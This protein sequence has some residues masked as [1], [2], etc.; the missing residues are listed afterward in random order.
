MVGIEFQVREIAFLLLPFLNLLCRSTNRV[1]VAGKKLQYLILLFISIV[2]V[3]EVLKH[4]YYGGGLGAT[5]KTIRIGLPLFSCLVIL[6]FGL[7]A[8]VEKVWRTLLW[9]ISASAV[10]T[11]I[12]PFVYLP[13]YP[14]IEGEN[15]IEATAGRFI[16][17]N[18][19]FGIIGVYLLYKDQDR[20]Y[21]KGLLV[22]I[23][24]ILSIIILILS[25]NRT[26]LA[27]LALA[28]VYLSFSEFS[29]R[30]AIKYV[31]I[32]F[33]ALGVF[34][35]FYNYSNVVQRQVDKRIISVLAGQTELVESVYVDSRDIIYMGI[36]EKIKK[37]NW[38]IGLP[39]SEKIFYKY[40]PGGIYGASKTD[41]SFVNVLLRY[42]IIP[43]IILGLIFLRFNKGGSFGMFAFIFYLIASLNIDSL[44]AHNSVLFLT[45]ILFVVNYRQNK[46]R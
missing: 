37:G 14:V 23:T 45:L 33:L 30:R 41:I 5:F 20:W 10:L 19:S 32:P 6:F 9:A 25:F 22:K 35:S 44:L 18:A 38:L 29:F 28:F 3:T 46:F 27:L 42:G 34:W 8:N 43:L 39:Y 26:Y 2:V 13:I 12:T 36:A 31:S 17:S 40:R 11:I 4:L 1:K 7:R 24:A 15:I 16:N 21:N